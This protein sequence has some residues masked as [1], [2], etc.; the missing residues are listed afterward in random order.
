MT[1]IIGYQGVGQ[2]VLAADS[3]VS[4]DS[5]LFVHQKMEKIVDNGGYLIA[6]AGPAWICE[7]IQHAWVPPRTDRPN[8]EWMVKQFAPELRHELMDRLFLDLNS[9]EWNLQLL[10]AVD[11]VIYQLAHDASVLLNDRRWYA[12]G[13][14]APFALGAMEMGATED[15]AL[16]IATAWDVNTRPPFQVVRQYSGVSHV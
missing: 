3:A 2:C 8:Y 14:G 1:T 4:V 16:K 11:G 7:H 12:I 9:D 6:A 5:T 15:E 13:T 10:V